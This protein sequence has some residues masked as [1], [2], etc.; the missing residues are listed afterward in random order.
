VNYYKID[1]R[2]IVNA[3][4]FQSI[5]NEGGPRVLRDPVTNQIVTVFN[6]YINVAST[7]TDGFDLEARYRA[8]TEFGRWTTRLNVTYVDNFKEDGTQY[9]GTNGGT[10]TIPRTRG[11]LALDWDYRAISS[12]LAGNYVRGYYQQLLAGT[13]FTPMDP[14]IQN[15]VYPDRVPS[16]ITYDIFGKYQL[17]K[18]LSVSGSVV[19]F[20]NRLPPLDPGFSSTFN[21]D[22]SMYDVRGRQY[23]LGLKYVL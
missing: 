1:W 22:F 3:P 15:Q 21:Y 17:T 11:Q 6:N 2:N 4:S 16:Y 20:T 10:N 8:S 18:N 12:T 14:R 19:N 7:V 9:A 5:V 13:F 23:R